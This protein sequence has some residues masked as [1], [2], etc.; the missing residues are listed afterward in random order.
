MQ[1]SHKSRAVRRALTLT[2]ALRTAPIPNRTPQPAT[3][4]P[5]PPSCR[6]RW[7]GASRDGGIRRGA[8]ETAHW[9]KP[10]V[11]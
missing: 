5:L 3:P 2:A 1:E 9:Q 8:P 4:C 6:G 10:S 7:H 11:R